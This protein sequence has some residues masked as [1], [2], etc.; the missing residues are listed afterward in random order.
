M[1]LMANAQ[2]AGSFDDPGGGKKSSAKKVDGYDK[3]SAGGGGRSPAHAKKV[4]GYDKAFSN[5]GTTSPPTGSHATAANFKSD[6][7]SGNRAWVPPKNTGRNDA[8]NR[9]AGSG[10]SSG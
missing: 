10:H 9:N 3:S 8:R 7:G 4:D 5:S 6:V 1:A 2:A